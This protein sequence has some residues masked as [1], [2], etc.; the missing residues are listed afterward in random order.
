MNLSRI[1]DHYEA[2]FALILSHTV[3]SVICSAVRRFALSVRVF[4]LRF[5]KDIMELKGG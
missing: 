2:P 4:Y 3:V 1:S 5:A